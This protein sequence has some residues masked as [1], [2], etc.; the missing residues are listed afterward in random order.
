MMDWTR[1][2]LTAG[3]LALAS[4]AYTAFVVEMIWWLPVRP[5]LILIVLT[6]WLAIRRHTVRSEIPSSAAKSGMV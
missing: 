5:A 6:F 3:A 1:G 2:L 4:V